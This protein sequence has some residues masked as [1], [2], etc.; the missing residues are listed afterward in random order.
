[1]QEIYN[2]YNSN[3]GKLRLPLVIENP[4]KLLDE[5]KY[6]YSLDQSL[7]FLN[8]KS[9]SSNIRVFGKI[10]SIINNQAYGLSTDNKYIIKK[11]D[12]DKLLF[13][14]NNWQVVLMIATGNKGI[15]NIKTQNISYNFNN[16]LPSTVAYEL[17]KDKPNRLCFRTLFKNDL[18]VDNSIY[19]NSSEDSITSGIYVIDE[20]IDNYVFLKSSLPSIS[21]TTNYNLTNDSVLVKNVGFTN[22][23]LSQFSNSRPNGNIIFE[24]NLYYRKIDNNELL[25][26]YVKQLEVIAII[27]D[28]NNCGFS[29][30]L[31]NT[32]VNTFLLNN[33][34]N[35]SDYVDNLGYPISD[36]YVGVI[37]KGGISG[38]TI[39][40]IVSNF[41]TLVE[42]TSDDYLEVINISDNNSLV[43]SHLSIGSKI[44]YS[45]CEYSY[46]KQLENE[47]EYINHCF[48]S[49]DSLIYYNPFQ[50]LILKSKGDL[51]SST[52]IVEIP[53]YALFSQLTNKYIW[54]E[55][56]DWFYVNQDTNQ[57]YDYPFLNGHIYVYVDF[58]LNVKI[59]KKSTKL[60]TKNDNDLSINDS[61]SEVTYGFNFKDIINRLFSTNELQSDNTDLFNQ[62]K[63]LKC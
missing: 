27:D 45:V 22:T 54:R 14:T 61:N 17:N 38:D 6:Y 59:E 51:L 42:F 62:Y 19:V 60:Y 33:T 31:Y 56:N 57:I 21:D 25:E 7:Q 32:D 9:G 36:L 47:V 40:N 34:I 52:N 63:N 8:E 53:S 50:K 29:K 11:I 30:N 18:E 24:P 20:V 12:N 37:K 49:N 28:F 43:S 44:L 13:N 4:T 26:Y 39:H 1:M 23:Q 41:S 5:E 16:G 10:N 2:K 35:I 48:I 3:N 15:K 58:N 46:E 55:L